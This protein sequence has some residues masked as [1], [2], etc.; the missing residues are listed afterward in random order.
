[1]LTDAAS[2]T[3]VIRWINMVIPAFPGYRPISD[4]L[5]MSNKVAPMWL[6]MACIKKLLPEP[7]GPASKMDRVNG[8]LFRISSEPF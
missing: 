7:C 3:L 6:H 5:L 1:V 8:V 2:N 4:E